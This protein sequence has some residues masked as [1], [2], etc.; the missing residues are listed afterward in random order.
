[1][2]RGSDKGGKAAGGGRAR[3]TREKGGERT[4]VT[5]MEEMSMRERIEEEKNKARKTRRA[6]GEEGDDDDDDD[7]DDDV[8]D[9]EDDEE[10]DAN[11]GPAFE[12]VQTN[13]LFGFSQSALGPS[14]EVGNKKP[15]GVKAIVKTQ[16]P[17]RMASQTKMVKA[18]NVGSA[19]AAEGAA[20]PELTRRERCVDM[21][22][23]GNGA[24]A[25]RSMFDHREAL[26]K[27]AAAARYMKKHLAGETVRLVCHE[28]GRYHSI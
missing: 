13:S 2:A 20:K 28:C 16:N 3:K 6:D 10:Q 23:Y 1:M 5:S 12:R 9:E 11:T 8:D 14:V 15:S 18:K 21:D 27:E 25:H 19:M 7:D 17:N 26:E 4:F 22:G 24:E